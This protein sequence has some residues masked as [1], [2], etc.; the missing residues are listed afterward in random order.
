MLLIVYFFFA[1]LFRVV[2]VD[3][4]WSKSNLY[5][6]ARFL[7]T[8]VK[9][10]VLPIMAC[11]LIRFNF[12]KYPEVHLLTLFLTGV[13][14]SVRFFVFIPLHNLLMNQI[15]IFRGLILILFAVLV[16]LHT[17]SSGSL[18]VPGVYLILLP[19]VSLTF[20]L[21]H[22]RYYNR[23]LQNKDVIDDFTFEIQCRVL[24]EE[25]KKITEKEAIRQMDTD[26]LAMF[27]KFE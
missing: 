15:E 24:L 16:T 10:G 8:A 27:R 1:F 2:K 23:V 7:D 26:C 4:S 11:F 18:Y 12:A 3:F 9:L 20:F 5:S 17:S 19:A 22:R 25:R 13:T 6:M 14:I 21:L